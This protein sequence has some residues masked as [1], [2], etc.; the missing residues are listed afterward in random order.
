[1]MQSFVSCL[2][3]YVPVSCERAIS[4][5]L[6][7]KLQ[8]VG[9]VST[10]EDVSSPKECFLTVEEHHPNR[11]EGPAKSRNPDRARVL[12]VDDSS[13]MRDEVSRT[14]RSHFDVVA[15]LSSGEAALTEWVA[16]DPDVIVL[17][18]SM[19]TISGIQV[20]R[21]LQECRCRSAI[22]F[23]TVHEDADFIAAAF[24][25]GASAYVKKARLN[26]DLIPAIRSVLAGETFISAH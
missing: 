2:S 11:A 24:D 7:G 12:L 18:I 8:W 20:A 10:L 5:C 1:M 25:A 14:L 4:L 15:S 13:A 19:G 26:L 9:S 16:F 23:L 3:R 22:V 6:N 17:D 21:Y